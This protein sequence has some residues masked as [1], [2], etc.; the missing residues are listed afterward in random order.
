MFTGIVS[1]MG[2]LTRV[3][4]QGE[5]LEL[6]IEAPFNDLA[7]GESIAVNGACL[8]VVARGRGQFRVQAVASTQGRTRF[9]EMKEGGRV[10]L[11]RALRLSDRLGGHLV[12]GHVD[13]LGEVIQVAEAGEGDNGKDTLLIDLRVPAE[14]AEIAVLHG[15]ITVDGVSLTVN[16]IPQPGVVQISLIP[17]TRQHTTLGRLRHGDK[18]HVEG[19][20]IGKFVRQ[21]TEG[22]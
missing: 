19:D 3:E 12:Q 11:E 14:V 21:L 9:A 8:T 1:A 20:L 2:T 6:T 10:N 22:R 18:V 15:S 5:T 7:D 13:A 17:Y 4:R 16:A